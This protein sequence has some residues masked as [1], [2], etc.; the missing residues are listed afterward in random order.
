MEAVL[1][2]LS[3]T[4]SLDGPILK[5]SYVIVERRGSQVLNPKS[6]MV[7]DDPHYWMMVEGYPNLKE[8][9]G[10]SISRF[11]SKSPRYLT[12]TCQVVNCLMRFGVGI[13][14]KIPNCQPS[15]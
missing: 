15:I 10:S 1:D 2:F 3:I 4:S 11:G 6:L 9:V 5:L 14:F 8:A 7:R 13:L 12:K